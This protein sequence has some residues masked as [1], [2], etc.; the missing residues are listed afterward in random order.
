[1]INR[2]ETGLNLVYIWTNISFN[3]NFTENIIPIS[4]LKANASKVVEDA[5]VNNQTYVITQNGYAKMVLIGI[6]EYDRM[7]RE[8]NNLS[9]FK[10]KQNLEKKISKIEKNPNKGKK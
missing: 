4:N 2:I 9:G 10:K 7:L 6:K 5:Y 1:M 8:L 3:M